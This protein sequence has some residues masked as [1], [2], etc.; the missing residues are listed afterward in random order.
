MNGVLSDP[1]PVVT[2]IRQ[3]CPLAPLLFLLV[4]EILNIAIVQNSRISGLCHPEFPDQE[5]KFSALVNDSTVFLQRAEQL[6]QVTNVRLW[7][8]L[9][10]ICSAGEERL[11]IPKYCSRAQGV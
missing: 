6:P 10:T 5:H 1:I 4:A 2:G 11:N 9:W 7:G 8:A 3:G